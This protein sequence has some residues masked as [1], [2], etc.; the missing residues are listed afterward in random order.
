MTITEYNKKRAIYEYLTRL[1]NGKM[2]ASLEAAKMVFVD[3][4]PWK[5]R[6]IR[7]YANYWLLNNK[8][9]VSRHGKHQKTIRLID[10]EDIAEKCRIWIHKQNFK[11]TP[12]T[13]K[14]FVE[15]ELQW[16]P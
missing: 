8:F 4:G 2:H 14:E 11:A 6:R 9:P 7:Y 15:K 13:F 1:N 12:T 3:G 10:D 5:A 16:L